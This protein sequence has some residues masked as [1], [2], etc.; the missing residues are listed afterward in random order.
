RIVELAREHGTLILEDDAYHDLRFS[1]ERLP[2]I[3]TLDDSGST[4]YLGT[5]SKIMGAGMRLGWLVGPEEIIT[6]LSVLKIDG[7]TNVFGSHVAAE[8]VPAHLD[9]HIAHLKETY[10]RRR[11]V[12]LVALERHMPPGTTWTRPDGGFFIWVTL[13]DGVDATR[14]LPMARERGVEYLAGATCYPDDRGTNQIRLSYSF[15]SD[16]QIDEGLRIIGEIVTGEL[17][18]SRGDS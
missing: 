14:M 7:C 6:K 18:E 12:M 11:D 8:W 5:F 9:G 3:Y 4:L 16:D 2:P 15:V 10:K 17:L 1:G 13:P